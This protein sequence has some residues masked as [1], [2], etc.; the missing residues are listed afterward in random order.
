MSNKK[1]SGTTLYQSTNK[2]AE[3]RKRKLL[4]QKKLQP[5]NKQLDTALADIH[6]R[7]KTPK[8]KVWSKSAIRLAKLF[9]EFS[10]SF[11]KDILSSNPKIAQ[12]AMNRHNAKSKIATTKFDTKSMF[13]IDARAKVTV[14]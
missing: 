6:W 10:G 1:S 12:E 3:N 14:L 7:R 9:G 8:T 11:D 5:N 4:K 13:S 2:F